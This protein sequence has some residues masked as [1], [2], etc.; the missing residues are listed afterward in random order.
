MVNNTDGKGKNGLPAERQC[1]KRLNAGYP[2]IVWGH[3]VYFSLNLL[4]I[5]S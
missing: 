5:G 3:C 4:L 1:Q 2:S